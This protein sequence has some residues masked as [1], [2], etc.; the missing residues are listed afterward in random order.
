MSE[1]LTSHKTRRLSDRLWERY[2]DLFLDDVPES[3]RTVAAQCVLDWLGC[4]LAGSSEPLT[5]ILRA[6][7]DGQTGPATLLGANIKAPVTV[8]ALINGSAGHALDYDDAHTTMGGHP[9]VPVLPAALAIA[10]EQGS[11]GAE[12]LA[13]FLVGVE[14][15]S[16]VGALFAG[17]TYARGWHCT[18][19]HGVFGAAAA[20]CHLLGADAETFGRAFGLAGSQASGL[21]VNFG[22][23]TKP[24]HAGH[25]A[26]RGAL[27][28]RLARR[29]FSAN[30]DVV[31]G[32]QGLAEASWE[33]PEAL[34]WD[35][36]DAVDDRWLIED[37]LFKYHAACYLTH[38]TIESVNRLKSKLGVATVTSAD[39]QEARLVVN[40]AILDVCGIPLPSTGLEAKF[41]LT[42][43]ASMA[44]LGFDTSSIDTFADETLA[45]S[46]L[47]ELIPRIEVDVDD[48]VTTAQARVLLD[49]GGGPVEAFTDM[50]IPAKDLSAQSEKLTAK[51]LALAKPF[52]EDPAALA[53][54]ALAVAQ[55]SHAGEL[56]TA[57]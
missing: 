10:E 43:T 44:L 3:A 13:A 8:A 22:T 37:T 5:E 32:R 35:R 7:F 11:T 36:L 21:K 52:A 29:G 9:T 45:D 16:R 54:R 39:L 4:A 47:Q 12:L 15:E 41:S 17:G 27:A 19:T 28:A 42:A 46:R 2:G 48:A 23:M 38:A 26:E 51:F 30:A 55:L 25:A 53:E 1:P 34:R 49:T 20:A 33:G 50:G 57:S 14:V 31:E 24:F 18:S 56:V 40:P 6:E